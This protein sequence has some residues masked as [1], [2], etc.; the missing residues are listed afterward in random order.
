[1]ASGAAD[2]I[3]DLIVL[4]HLALLTQHAPGSTSEGIA[5]R[6]HGQRHLMPYC[7]SLESTP[8]AVGGLG[9]YRS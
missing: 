7:H 3:R 4:G 6:G 5:Q 9:C 2:N 1:M 8:A